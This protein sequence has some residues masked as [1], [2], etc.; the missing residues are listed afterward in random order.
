VR[1]ATRVFALFMKS[2]GRQV[3][4][5][6][7]QVL[8]FLPMP[9]PPRNSS[10]ALEVRATV[11]EFVRWDLMPFDLLDFAGW[12]SAS[13]AQ[14]YV[15]DSKKGKIDT[16]LMVAGSASN[17]VSAVASGTSL[18]PMQPLRPLG[19]TPMLAGEGL[20]HMFA[21][22]MMNASTSNS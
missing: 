12:H 10:N 20:F 11:R 22:A 4:P 6:V 17:P 16:A 5:G 13:V 2:A 3:I 21:G 1:D 18:K 8:R 9:V 19:T 15:A 14:S 7:V